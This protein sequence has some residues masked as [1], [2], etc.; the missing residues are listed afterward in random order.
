MLIP[1]M[2]DFIFDDHSWPIFIQS[3]II[4][5]LIGLS[6]VLASKQNKKLVLEQRDAFIL[7]T[8]SWFV[9]G[10]L[11]ALPFILLSTNSLTITDAFFEAISG[12]TTT[13]ATVI[14][15]LN[16]TSKGI[17]LWRSMLQWFGG[18]GIILIAMSIL[19]ILHIGG[20]Q[21]FQ[22]ES[23]D[24]SEKILPKVSQVASFIFGIYCSLTILCGFLLWVVGMSPFNALCHGLTTMATGGFSTADSSIA[25]FDNV[26]VELIMVFFMSL[27]GMTFVLIRNVGGRK[28]SVFLQDPQVRLYFTIIICLTFLVSAWQIFINEETPLQAARDSLFQITSFLTTSGFTSSNYMAWGSFPIL[29]ILFLSLSGSCTGSTSG[30]IKLFR[31]KIMWSLAVVQLKKLRRPHGVFIA[32][33]NKRALNEHLFISVIGFVSLYIASIVIL[34]IFL[35]FF[36]IDIVTSLSTAISIIGNIGPG[37]G[38]IIGPEGNFSTLPDAAKWLLMF[39]MVAGRLELLTVFA[40]FLPSFWKN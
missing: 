10:A 35:T 32:H 29:L 1:A 18:I 24:Q 25:A 40:L 6:L 34:S 22:S 36:N 21:L 7:T 37:I 15:G 14:T 3:A 33:Y 38:P 28:I 30:G 8:L 5:F 20:M 26:W 31:I 23:S 2:I 19:P 16:S 12:L 9:L 11:S 13:G 17:L 4:T 39:G 27:S